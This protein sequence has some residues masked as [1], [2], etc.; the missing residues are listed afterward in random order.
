M[1]L[2]RELAEVVSDIAS[3]AF[4]TH[5]GGGQR[6]RL[7]ALASWSVMRTFPSVDKLSIGIVP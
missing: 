6:Q 1:E 4:P 2:Q 5:H 3:Q 7:G